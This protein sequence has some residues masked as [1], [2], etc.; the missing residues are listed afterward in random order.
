VSVSSTIV[1]IGAFLFLMWFIIRR[2]KNAANDRKNAFDALKFYKTVTIA[3]DEA[4]Y[5]NISRDGSFSPSRRGSNGGD[6]RT[7][8]VDESRRG[9][10]MSEMY[11]VDMPLTGA[12]RESIRSAFHDVTP[13]SNAGSGDSSPSGFNSPFGRSRRQSIQ[14]MLGNQHQASDDTAESRLAFSQALRL[15]GDVAQ[16]KMKS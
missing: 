16:K 5:R 6:S 3:A 12:R 1:G 9:S 11:G 10:M 15:A 13:N 14:P 8:D 2:R 4:H 7:S